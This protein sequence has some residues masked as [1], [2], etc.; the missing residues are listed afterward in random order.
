MAG[1][2]E[3]TNATTE[4]SGADREVLSFLLDSNAHRY[5]P[6]AP[7]LGEWYGRAA[8]LIRSLHRDLAADQADLAAALATDSRGPALRLCGFDPQR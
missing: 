7:A 4:M 6:L 1:F 3:L 5:A 8:D 2:D